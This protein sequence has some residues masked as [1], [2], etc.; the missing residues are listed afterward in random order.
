MNRILKIGVLILV[1]WFTATGA[2][3]I[4][5]S[6]KV[7]SKYVNSNA[8]DQKVNLLKL[9][10][11]FMSH[12][13]LQQKQPIPVWGTSV[14]NESVTVT[15]GAQTKV[16]RSSADGSWRI[17]LD[18]MVPCGTL[19]MN[20]STADGANVILEDILVGE[21][22]LCA[23][24]S[25]MEFKLGQAV[26]GKEAVLESNHPEI[27]LF[28][29]SGIVRPDPVAWD[30]KSLERI[31]KMDLFEGKWEVCAPESS[32]NFSAI[33]YFF[34]ATLAVSRAVPVGLIE[35]A[36]GGAPAESFIAM[37]NLGKD[38]ILQK[39][40]V[41]W[42]HNELVMEWCRQRAFQN[43]A[44]SVDAQQRH[45]FEPSYIYESGVSS[46]AGFPIKG[47][48]WYQGESNADNAA[49]YERLLPALVDSW[50]EGWKSQNLPFYFAQLSGLERKGWPEFRDTQRRLTKT[51]ST[52]GMVVTFDLGDSLNVHPARKKEV[53][54]R[55]AS[56]ALHELYGNAKAPVSP[57]LKKLELKKNRLVLSFDHDGTLKT[58]DGALPRE[59]EIAGADGDFKTAQAQIVGNKLVVDTKGWKPNMIRYGW[60]PFSRGNLVNEANLPVATFKYIINK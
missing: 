2:H 26:G 35:L 34:G 10:R 23:G 59:I 55:F 30:K 52:S 19:R 46:L 11:P 7:L 43:L 51:I 1:L 36:V 16:G 15:I 13:V 21:V 53:G 25:N 48:I 56:L 18:A 38:S 50:R 22:W 33:G 28:N 31:N 6:G 12:M 60:K 9:G 42:K 54:E 4:F 41:D 8:C 47:V 5:I 40:A 27:R 29:L 32:T 39:L 44:N 17:V 58:S 57:E 24:Q 45:P 49:L 37:K 14:P 20:I 3:A